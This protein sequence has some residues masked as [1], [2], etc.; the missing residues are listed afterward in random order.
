MVM[1]KKE[2]P[3]GSSCKLLKVRDLRLNQVATKAKANIFLDSFWIRKRGVVRRPK[4]H[5]IQGETRNMS[6]KKVGIGF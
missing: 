1:G 5:N 6:L 4:T 3:S 2:H